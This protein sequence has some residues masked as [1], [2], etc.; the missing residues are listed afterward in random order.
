MSSP[1]W[2]AA[3]LMPKREAVATQCL[4]LAGFE[5]YLP[6]LRERRVIRGRRVEV[7]PPLFP[8]YLFI[9]IEVQWSRAR[10]APGVASLIMAGDG[11]ARVPDSVIA[12]IRSR[13]RNGL[14]E[15]ARPPRFRRGDHVR[16]VRGPFRERL[17]LY[18]GMGPHE[19]IAVLL[20]ILG[21][22]QRVEL[23]AGDIVPIEV[24]P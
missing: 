14:V 15:L 24:A 6:R 5:T 2:C 10:W 20:Q 22:Q 19:R 7:S 1:F 11:P 21:G 17:A 23:P 9:W 16:I 3:R 18:D 12:E 4:A 8:C 13:E